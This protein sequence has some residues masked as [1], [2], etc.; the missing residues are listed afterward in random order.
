MGKKA[1][2]RKRVKRAKKK[3]KTII[4]TH[5]P[6]S[7]RYTRVKYPSTGLKHLSDFTVK[8]IAE[9]APAQMFREKG[10][11]EQS[12]RIKRKAANTSKTKDIV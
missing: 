10:I 2:A 6:V 9:R 1:D 8:A 11:I 12:R 4:S 5:A 7:A 3:I